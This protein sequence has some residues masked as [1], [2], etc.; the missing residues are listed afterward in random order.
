VLHSFGKTA[1][2]VYPQ[3]PL[4][5]VN[6]ML[7]GTT[8]TNKVHG[9]P[10]GPGTVFRMDAAGAERVLY[11]F[12]GGADGANPAGGLID[13]DGTLY[14]TTQNGGKNGGGTI[15][16]LNAHGS[17]ERVLHSFG[18][19]NDGAR[20]VAGLLDVNGTLYGTTSNGGGTG[21]GGAGCGTVF[22]YTP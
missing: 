15:F 11:A 4:M 8:F 9:P 16:S 1:D 6:G 10:D 21:C 17:G 5:N 3:A 12:K 2:G 19:G 7:Y 22:A 20:P 13:V 14:G 18:Q